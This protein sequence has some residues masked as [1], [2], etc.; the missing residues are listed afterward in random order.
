[1][2][3]LIWSAA[4]AGVLTLSGL[5]NPARADD[6][7]VAF[8]L[9][10]IEFLDDGP[11]AVALGA[12]GFNVIPNGEQGDTTAELRL[13]YRFGEK[14]HAIGPLVG[15]LVTSEGELFAYVAA[16]ADLRVGKRWIITP[17][18]GIGAYDEGDGKYLGGTFQF[19]LG[20][21]LAYQFDTGDRL[22]LKL[23]HISNASINGSNPG[24]ESLLLTYTLLL[25][26]PAP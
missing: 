23:A 25:S 7:P 3:S 9:G 4:M 1:M 10:G 6:Q 15:A 21:D 22:G 26:P 24:T 19:H 14:W 17:A 2:K 18:A 11:A 5:D 12:G 16:Y 13:E 20:L 8:T